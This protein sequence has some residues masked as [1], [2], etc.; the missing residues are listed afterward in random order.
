[1]I[2]VGISGI[3][4]YFNIVAVIEETGTMILKPCASRQKRWLKQARLTDIIDKI[5]TDKSKNAWLTVL[6][7]LGFIFV[8]LFFGG[9]VQGTNSDQ[10]N[11][12]TLSKSGQ[13]FLHLKCLMKA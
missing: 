7:F 6:G 3:R 13:L 11:N 8:L 10:G 9:L 4:H 5:S 2:G 12:A 1:M